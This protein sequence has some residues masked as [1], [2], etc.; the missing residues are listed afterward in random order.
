M[1]KQVRDILKKFAAR[2]RAVSPGLYHYARPADGTMARFHLRVDASG[3]GLLLA[4]A[5][6]MTRLAPSGVM[7]AKGLLDGDDRAAIVQRVRDSFRGAG[8]GANRR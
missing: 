5:T 3:Y 6:A 1:L 8:G 7:I 2:P 4:N